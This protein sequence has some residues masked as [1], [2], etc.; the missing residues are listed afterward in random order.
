[1]SRRRPWQGGLGRGRM[2]GRVLASLLLLSLGC[3]RETAVS[4][5]DCVRESL[6][7][8]SLPTVR[9]WIDKRSEAGPSP[10]SSSLDTVSI[11]TSLRHLHVPGLLTLLAIGRPD[12]H[13]PDEVLLE[14]IPWERL[15]ANVLARAEDRAVPLL[16]LP[17]VSV[18][19][20]ELDQARALVR[21][22]QFERDVRDVVASTIDVG[23][24]VAHLDGG[25]LIR[26]VLRRGPRAVSREWLCLEGL[27]R[28]GCMWKEWPEVAK[29]L[30]KTGRVGDHVLYQETLQVLAGSPGGAAV[31]RTVGRLLNNE[32][33]RLA[34]ILYA[35]SKGV[36]IT[37]TQLRE[38][39]VFFDTQ[40]PQAGNVAVLLTPSLAVLT[41]QYHGD[42][43]LAA[44]E[45][46]GEHRT[47]ES[48]R[49]SI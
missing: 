41:S 34:L 6:L 5:A 10:S 3:H 32:T 48:C 18:S 31:F 14:A 27:G 30:L 7:A 49:H 47:S 35:R 1:M 19:K 20:R 29:S 28:T 23:F 4:E 21:S 11:D 37:D 17:T 43:V 15:E 26:S 2:V 45:R 9:A 40:S 44:L 36:A 24:E 33:V 38:V 13:K 39:A 22:G 12:P 8:Q 46:L 16:G 25:A 42:K